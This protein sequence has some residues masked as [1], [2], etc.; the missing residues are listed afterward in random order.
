M[1]TPSDRTLRW[2]LP[3]G[4]EVSDLEGALRE[5]GRGFEHPIHPVF[6]EIHDMIRTTLIPT[7]ILA[8]T[9]FPK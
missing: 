4:G 2:P 9:L 1:R 3:R 6:G 7:M 8:K 5:L